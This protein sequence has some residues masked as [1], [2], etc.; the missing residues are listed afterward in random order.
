MRWRNA[1]TAELRQKKRKLRAANGEW[2]RSLQALDQIR[3]GHRSFLSGLVFLMIARQSTAGACR[4]KFTG[5]WDI[6]IAR[7][8]RAYE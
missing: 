2:C 3:A 4:S 7:L 5:L 6:A 8:V 1:S